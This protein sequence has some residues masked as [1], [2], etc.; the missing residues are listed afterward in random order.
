MPKMELK[1]F[2]HRVRDEVQSAYAERPDSP[3]LALRSIEL[4]VA[5]TL[6]ATG[7]VKG[8]LFVVDLEGEVNHERTHKVTLT[9]VPVAPGQKRP[10]MTFGGVGLETLDLPIAG[11]PHDDR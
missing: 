6:S 7:G 2:I 3:T 8:T 1:D 10:T 4:E 9:L 5:F 11:I